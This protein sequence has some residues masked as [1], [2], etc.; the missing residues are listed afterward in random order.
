MTSL[1][2]TVI[3]DD[4]TGLVSALTSL[5]EVRGGSWQRS[6]MTRL[7]GKFAGVAEVEVPADAVDPLR[8]DLGRLAEDGLTVT[9]ETSEQPGAATRTLW[10][11]H[12]LGQDRPGILA[13]IS[14]ALAGHGVGIEEL[15]TALT[16]APMAGGRLFEVDALLTVPGATDEGR[17]RAELERLA[18]E[19]MVDLT[20]GGDEA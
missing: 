1:V 2:L 9:V 7:A 6:R 12:L 4:R 14:T 19:L 10:R 15:D 5:V 18:D 17:V 16:D 11:L 8:T 3:G 20:V 13:E